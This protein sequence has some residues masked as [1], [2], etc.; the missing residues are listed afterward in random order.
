MA[1]NK[2]GGQ[3]TETKLAAL[4]E[5]LRSYTQALKNQP[6]GLHYIDA[7]AGAGDY[8]GKSGEIRPGSA[9]IALGINGFQHYTFIE[10]KRSFVGHLERLRNDFQDKC[11]EIHRGDA[12]T[13]L[14]RI[15]EPGDWRSNRGVLFLDPY[16][17][18]VPWS[19][20]EQIRSTSAIDV[21]YLLPL[22][23]LLRQMTVDPARRDA[24]KDKALDRVLG[25]TQWRTQLYRQPAMQDMFDPAKLEREG[26]PEVVCGWLTDRLS[27]LFP[28]AIKVA[29][30]RRGTA[31]SPN[32]GPR[33]F[34]LYFLVSN[35]SPRALGLARKLANG[36]GEKLRRE[37]LIA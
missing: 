20:L 35:D 28:C 37:G 36:V 25:T 21:W 26:D 14:K 17:M 6:F 29:T 9:R 7:F 33:L 11:I 5:Y 31:T 8:Q 2:F 30:L 19:T 15:C 27:S 18:H 24:D 12:N 13:H 23:G 4:R 10:R 16:G 34:A 32:A 3:W 1:T 22:N